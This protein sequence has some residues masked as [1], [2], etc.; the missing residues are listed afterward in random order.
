MI[1]FALVALLFL[2]APAAI[3]IGKVISMRDRRG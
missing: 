1:V 2:A 3:V